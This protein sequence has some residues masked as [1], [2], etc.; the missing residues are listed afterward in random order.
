MKTIF[1]LLL[2]LFM[3]TAQSQRPANRGIY[4]VPNTS[5]HPDLNLG[6]SNG[7][8]G[9][10]IATADANTA[11]RLVASVQLPHGATIDSVRIYFIDYADE[12]MFVSL[13]GYE[14]AKGSGL[15]E[16]FTNT[17]NGKSN[18]VRSQK[19]LLGSYIIDN[20]KSSYYLS[21]QPKTG[22]PKFANTLGIRSVVFY[23][24]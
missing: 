9:D 10:G 2:T 4:T 23:Y 21:V 5:F 8:A 11:V 22:W 18:A 20:E 7:N 12:D 13:I 15:K 14:N 6:Y 17:T 3:G 24:H 19:A 16:I 1:F